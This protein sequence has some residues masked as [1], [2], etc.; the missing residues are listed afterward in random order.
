VALFLGSVAGCRTLRA[1]GDALKA[2]SWRQTTGTIVS[3]VVTE[4]RS[5]SSPSQDVRGRSRASST[6]VTHD[7]HVAYRYEVGG[8]THDGTRIS[9]GLRPAGALELHGRFLRGARVPVFYDPDDPREAC[10]IVAPAEFPA[11]HAAG[12]GI[13]LTVGVAMMAVV[14]RF[15]LR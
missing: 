8:T 11:W 7:L 2:Q 1:H 14:G 3:S 5:T 15:V 13:L 12:A 4:H 10:L 6:S 9:M